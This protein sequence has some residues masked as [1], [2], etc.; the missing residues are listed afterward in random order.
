[1]HL[2]FCICFLYILSL[3]STSI[4]SNNL[5]IGSFRFSRYITFENNNSYICSFLKL[6]TL[7]FFILTNCLS[8]N[9]FFHVLNLN[10]GSWH[11]CHIL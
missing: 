7:S 6:V 8:Y 2:I 5:S 3:I 10:G 9:I 11:P 1:M 4:N